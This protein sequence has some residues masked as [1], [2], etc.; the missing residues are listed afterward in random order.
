MRGATET[1]TKKV[2]KDL[3]STPDSVV[4]YFEDFIGLPITLD[5]ASS[6]ANAVSSDFITEA[7]DSLKV[8]WLEY[9]KE[10]DGLVWLNPP[11]SNITPFVEKAIEMAD[12]GANVCVLV[13]NST[14]AHWFHKASD[15]AEAIF[16]P[17]GRIGFVSAET[18]DR[19]G[20]N[21]R[22]TAVFYFKSYNPADIGGPAQRHFRPDVKELE[23][24]PVTERLKK[25]NRLGKYF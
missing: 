14:C 9:Y 4:S 7:E 17:R 1:K 24:H 19:V 21:D 8:N 23:N 15:R 18:G 5:A 20:R 2:N 12:L 11:F 10:H 6:S 22:G 13:T 16:L 3:W 25:V